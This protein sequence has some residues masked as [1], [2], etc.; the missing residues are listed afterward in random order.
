MTLEQDHK[1]LGH[2]W[3]KCQN[4]EICEAWVDV[5]SVTFSVDLLSDTEFLVYTVPKTQCGITWNQ[6]AQFLDLIS[7]TYRWESILSNMYVG[8]LTLAQDNRDKA[9]TD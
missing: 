1:V 2:S 9:K 5:D 3:N 4:K 8:H 6:I 7:G